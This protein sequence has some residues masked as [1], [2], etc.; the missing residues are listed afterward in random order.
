[1]DI[2]FDIRIRV[3]GNNGDFTPA[4][5]AQFGDENQFMCPICRRRG[6]RA[7]VVQGPNGALYAVGYTCLRRFRLERGMFS[8]R[9]EVHVP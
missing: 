3:R 8:G 2:E 7:Y 6:K 9:P 4:F 5:K 1:M